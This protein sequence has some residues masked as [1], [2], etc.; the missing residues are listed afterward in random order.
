M[1][2]P[3]TKIT[4]S[5]NFPEKLTAYVTKQVGQSLNTSPGIFFPRR[6]SVGRYVSQ[7]LP[8]LQTVFLFIERSPTETRAG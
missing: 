2:G 4:Y 6:T 7:A 3:F 5:H 8:R 1:L